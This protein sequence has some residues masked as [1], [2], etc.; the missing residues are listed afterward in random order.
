M[1]TLL[2]EHGYFLLFLGVMVE[3]EGVLLGA[4]FLAHRGYFQLSLVILVAILGNCTAD[5]TYYLLARRRGRAWLERRFGAH[6]RYQRVLSLMQRHANWLLVGSRFAFGFRII[7]PAACGALGMAPLRF[8]LINIAA[9]IAW[10]VPTALLGYYFGAKAEQ[11]LQGA[12][13]YE[14]WILSVFVL[15]AALVVLVRHLK[16]TEWVEDL[17]LS[18]LHG[19][20]PF[21]VGLMGLINLT[22][23]IWPPQSATVKAVESWLPLEVTQQSRPLMLFAGLALLQVTRNLTRRKE[24]AWYVAT[25]ALAVSLLLH[26]THG[27]DLHHSLVAGSLLAYLIYFRRRFYARSDPSSLRLALATVPVLSVIVFA[28]GYFGL[29][30]MHNRF[31]WQPAANPINEAFR[32]G[33]LIREPN[34]KP[35]TVHAARFLGSLQIAGWL[36]RFYF[37]V[38]VLRP[39]IQRDRLE[40]PQGALRRIFRMH[41]QKSLSAFA[42]QSDKHH[43]LVANGHGLIAYATRGSIALACGDPLAPAAEFEASVREYLAFSRKNGWTPCVYEAAEDRLPAYQAMGLRSLK[44]AEEALLD[45]SEFSLAGG[46]R[47]NLR[48]MINKVLKSGLSVSRYDRK[49]RPDAA[50][51]E[52]LESI[53]QQ[54]LS[55]KKLGEMG[56]TLG[57]FSLESLQDDWVFVATTD[58]CIDAFCTWLPYRNGQ[59]AV[60]DLMRKREEAPA[61]TMDLLLAHSLLQLKEIGIPEASLGN[62]PLANVAEPRG[63]LDQGVALLFE[64]MNSFYGYKNLFQFKKKFAPCWEGRYLI[65]PSGADLPR[66]AW[67]LAS[68]HGPGG[69]L[70][71]LLRR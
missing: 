6:T 34:V 2:I 13:R 58:G 69:L 59:A 39:V 37:L 12:K 5:Q 61:G 10:A 20:V 1:E 71:L 44:I 21:F 45:L 22:S 18:D 35:L 17:K 52:Q 54:W 48:A 33:I 60:L 65:Y 55:K 47:A 49:I 25:T 68:V 9:G 67:A 70:Q 7:I 14:L 32:S 38:L 16:K 11:W 26:I 40:A 27:L 64:N 30:H 46:K 3:G 50:I 51:D 66:V 24:L 15:A 53:S 56:F 23:A 8:A 42:I 29:T 31:S 57:R 63:R 19:A 62:A 41:G 28:Y 36:A 4:S 43:L